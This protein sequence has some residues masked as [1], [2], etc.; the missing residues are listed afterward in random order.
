MN[1]RYEPV[2]KDEKFDEVMKYLPADY[3]IFYLGAL[4]QK[5]TG[6]VI[7]IGNKY[8]F[9]QEF[10]TGSQAYSIQTGRMKYF[11]QSLKDYEW[12][13]DLGLQNFAK[14]KNLKA[15]IAQ[16]NLVTQFPS[17]SDLRLEEVDDF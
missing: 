2:T 3:D 10:T 7:D 8:W 1:K 6:K 5:R 17:Y 12:Y 14:E 9:K 13:I 15:F 4:I 16:P 11:H